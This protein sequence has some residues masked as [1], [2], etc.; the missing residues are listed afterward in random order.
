MACSHRSTVTCSASRA[1]Y[2]A[3]STRR[4]LMGIAVVILPFRMHR[5]I[6]PDGVSINAR[7][8]RLYRCTTT[9]PPTAPPLAN[10]IWPMTPIL[11]MTPEQNE[12]IVADVTREGSRLRRFIRRYVD[13]GDAED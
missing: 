8:I 13:E 5:K 12:R 4:H 9:T 10:D 7:V 11:S 3:Q 6:F 2:I 1:A